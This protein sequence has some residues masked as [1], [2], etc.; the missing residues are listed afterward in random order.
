M[1]VLKD[2]QQIDGG[3]LVK[4]INKA[5]LS[6]VED[7]RRDE[8]LE[9]D[10]N[11]A[12]NIK[13]TPKDGEVVLSYDVTPKL[14]KRVGEERGYLDNTRGVF[15]LGEPQARLDLPGMGMSGREPTGLESE[16][17]VPQE[18]ATGEGGSS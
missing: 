16:E 5:I 12:I 3:E 18:G 10:R 2:I 11:I 9:K 8:S 7:I 15:R 17:D 1:A 14:A 4:E 6:C 13:F